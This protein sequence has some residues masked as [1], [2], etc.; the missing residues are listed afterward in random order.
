MY[1]NRRCPLTC[2]IANNDFILIL[3]AVLGMADVSA[4]FSTDSSSASAY[5]NG[6]NITGTP[7]NGK[8]ETEQKQKFLWIINDKTKFYE[9][10]VSDIC[11]TI[12]NTTINIY[13]NSKPK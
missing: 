1:S 4:N 10:F 7:S 13:I 3:T 2:H 12:N 8:S 9:Y 11:I 6:P 5:N